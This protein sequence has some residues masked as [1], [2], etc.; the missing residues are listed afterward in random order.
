M[1]TRIDSIFCLLFFQ[2]VVLV[3]TIGFISVGTLG[4]LRIRQHFDPV[5]LLP[6][7]TYLR[8]WIGV[9]QRH[10]PQVFLLFVY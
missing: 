7:D 9:H 4:T 5:L 6:A 3:L 8:Q 10:F 1:L 2:V